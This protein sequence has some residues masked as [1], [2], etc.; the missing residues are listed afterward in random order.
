MPTKRQRVGRFSQKITAAAV[1]AYR[2]R[3][4]AALHV[5]LRLPPWNRSPLPIAEC[6]LGV[7]QGEPPEDERPDP[8]RNSWCVARELR[9]ELEQAFFQHKKSN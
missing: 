3:D 7:D 2:A 5:A 6:A 8:W 9:S 1:Q 4:Y